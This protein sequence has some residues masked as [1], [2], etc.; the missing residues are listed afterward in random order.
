MQ[1]ALQD[2][3]GGAHERGALD[4]GISADAFDRHF[5]VDASLRM[6]HRDARARRFARSRR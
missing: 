6:Q 5:D 1:V 4:A 2:L 3:S